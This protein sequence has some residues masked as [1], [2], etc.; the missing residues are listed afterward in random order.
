MV[1]GV[2]T[3]M[4]PGTLALLTPADFHKVTPGPAGIELLDVGF[5][6]EDL[7][8][9][10][11]DLLLG[12][13]G[14]CQMTAEGAEREMLT[15]EF[16]RLW[17]EQWADRI[18]SRRILQGTLE[19]ILIDLARSWSNES[20]EAPQVTASKVRRAVVYLHHHFREPVTLADVAGHAQLSPHY[21]SE[22]FHKETT[23]TFQ[24]YLRDLRLRF[25][26]SLLQMG[27][28][29][30]TEVCLASGFTTLSHFERAF[31]MVY[32]LSPTGIRRP[33]GG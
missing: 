30:V 18:G 13:S 29:P 4:V 9:E 12:T 22:C 1:N 23:V 25:A 21:F 8:H 6:V 15:A 27:E 7:H 5:A 28:L 19:R 26:R 16:W 17:D 32:G 2:E 3:A 11:S 31:K 14:P 24:R 33:S 20:I 10:L